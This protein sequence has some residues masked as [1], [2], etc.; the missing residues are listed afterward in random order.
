MSISLDR[1]A[2]SRRVRAGAAGA[3]ATGRRWRSRSRRPTARTCSSTRPGAGSPS[4]STSPGATASSSEGPDSVGPWPTRRVHCGTDCSSSRPA[5]M[6]FVST[7][8]LS[9]SSSPRC[10]SAPSWA[11]STPASSRCHCRPCRRSSAPRWSRS[12]GWHCPT[13]SS[14]WRTVTALGRL[15]D[16]FGR[17]LLYTYGFAVFTLAT[18]GCGLAPYLRRA[19]R[20]PGRPG[21]R[22]G[23]AAGQ[24]RRADRHLAAARTG[25][26]E[27]LGIQG[28]A[29]ALGLALGPTVGGLLIAAGGWRWVFFAT[30]PAGVIGTVAGLVPP[31]PYPP[32]RRAGDVRLARP[33]RV[34]ARGAPG[35]LAGLSYGGGLGV[36]WSCSR[37]RR[38]PAGRR[39]APGG[40][41]RCCPRRCSASGSSPAAIA[42][43]L[44]SYLALFG[45]LFSTPF[46]AEEHLHLSA[47]STGLLLTCLPAALG[48]TAPIAGAAADRLGGRWFAVIGMVVCRDRVGAGGHDRTHDDPAGPAARAGRRR[49]RHVHAGQQRVGHDRRRPATVRSGRGRAQHDPRARHRAGGRDGRPRVLAGRGRGELHRGSVPPAGCWGSSPPP[50]PVWSAGRRLSRTGAVRHTPVTWPDEDGPS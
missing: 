32:A 28:A 11:S 29:Q 31:A 7:A 36:P 15:G 12:S 25:V 44:L 27:G 49:V 35:L 5:R 19:H 2:V 47:A 43:G 6:S 14:S 33:R 22:C 3:D 20:L 17:K 50:A 13:W 37:R 24:Q 46:Y 45:L 34:R 39:R 30:V 9:G 41:R 38:R 42:A 26:P 16:V 18:I 40:R 48:L 21:T 4:C 1:S 23:D 10:A 8:V